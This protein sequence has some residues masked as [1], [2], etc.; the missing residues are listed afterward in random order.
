MIIDIH[1]HYLP[2]LVFD[3]FEQ[4]ASKFPDVALKRDDKGVR[5]GFVGKDL[6]RPI[7]PK[8]SALA[9]RRAWM[10]ANGIDHQLV[11]AWMDATGYELPPEQGLAWSRFM[12]ACT[13]ENLGDEKRFTP[14]ATV[15]MQSGKLA[16]QVLEEAMGQGFGGVMV[17]TLPS[18]EGGNLDSPDLDPFWE[19]A[20][21]LNA[22][23]MLHPMFVC[24]EPRLG[25]YDLV[26]AIG[27][28]VDTS[29]AV[30]RLLFSGHLL[31]YPGAKL[32]LSHGG[33][34]LPFVL[35]RLGRHYDHHGDKYADP[36]KGFEALY[37]DAL[38][39]DADSTSY[40]I[41]KAGD[42]KVMMGSD[43]PFPA[44]DPHPLR[45]IDEAVK[46]A[47]VRRKLLEENARRVF[48]VRPDCAMPA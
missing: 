4:E 7:M 8:L 44:G 21:R 19:T 26:N 38:V 27:R 48:R 25:D 6:S 22:A 15:P 20:S 30:S 46:D 12:N 41:D 18:G 36:R 14:L 28:V 40:L 33:A 11:G 42:D 1:A 39:F 23:V 37:F 32:V 43:M 3:R 34:A 35:G 5:I 17:G 9:D 24:G 2:Q 16:A 13:L 29:I 10:D 47:A 31:K 45:P